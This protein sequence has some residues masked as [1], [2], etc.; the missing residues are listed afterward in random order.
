MPTIAQNPVMVSYGGASSVAVTFASACTNPS[1]IVAAAT[2]ENQ[3]G[4]F[5][6]AD[7]ANAGTYVDDKTTAAANAAEYGNA[8]IRRKQSTATTAATVTCTLGAAST[9]T[10]KCYELTGADTTNAFDSSAGDGTDGGAHSITVTTVAA[11]CTMISIGA[12]YPAG[13]VVDSGYTAAF[14]EHGGSFAYHF[15]EHNA[16]VGAAGAKTLTYG[17]TVNRDYHAFVAVAYKPAAA[18]GGA[19]R[20]TPFGGRGNAFNGGRILQGVIR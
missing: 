7:N 19:T 3:A 10:F 2:Q 20:G 8:T 6:I 15:G 14:A 9:G 12:H 11:N 1:V 18:G 5:S 16:D 4:T 13:A 17:M